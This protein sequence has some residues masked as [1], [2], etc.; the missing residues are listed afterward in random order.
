M[1]GQAQRAFS[2]TRDY[3]AKVSRAAFKKLFQHNKSLVYRILDKHFFKHG[4]NL[5]PQPAKQFCCLVGGCDAGKK[6]REYEGDLDH[7]Q[8]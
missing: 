8:W 1:R 5:G 2:F 7:V 3:P 4:T 6:W